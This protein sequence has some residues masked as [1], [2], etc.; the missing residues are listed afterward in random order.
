VIAPLGAN[1]AFDPPV[2]PPA[3]REPLRLLFVGYDWIRKGGPLVLEAFERLKQ[4][5]ANAELHLVGCSPAEAVGVAG[6]TIHGKLNKQD[7]DQREKLFRLFSE[8]SFMFMPTRYEAFGLVFCEACAFS[9]PPVAGDTGGV[10]TIIRNGENGLLLPYD[11]APDDYAK[12]ILAVWS[13]P[14]RYADMRAKAR[15]DFESRLSWKAWGRTM[16]SELER[17]ANA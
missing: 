17:I 8:S 10:G 11:A 3:R 7:A 16:D 12:A 14:D 6:V 2:L 13:D 4:T 15:S 5:V 9:L 1:I